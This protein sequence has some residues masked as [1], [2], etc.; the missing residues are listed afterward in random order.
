MASNTPSTDVV[1]SAFD[2]TSSADAYPYPLR[3]G[4][5]ARIALAG[6]RPSSEY[7]ESPGL[8]PPRARASSAAPVRSAFAFAFASTSSAAASA[9]AAS[10]S[11]PT[12]RRSA[13][14]ERR[15]RLS[16]GRSLARFAT[17]A[18]L[19]SSSSSSSGAHANAFGSAPPCPP[20]P[21]RRRRSA[22]A[23]SA[24]SRFASSASLSFSTSDSRTRATARRSERIRANAAIAANAAAAPR[25]A[26]DRHPSQHGTLIVGTLIVGTL[27][28][29]TRI[30]GTRIVG[31]R[32]GRKRGGVRAGGWRKRG[33]AIDHTFPTRA[34]RIVV[35]L[36]VR[37][38]AEIRVDVARVRLPR[39]VIVGEDAVAHER[40]AGHDG[41]PPGADPPGDSA[42]G[43]VARLGGADD[44][45][46]G[47]AVHGGFVT[48]E[49]AVFEQSAS[50]V[51]GDRA[52]AARSVDVG[53]IVGEDD[54][55][56]DERAV[57]EDGAAVASRRP[58][59]TPRARTT[60]TRVRS[61]RTP[62]V[63][64]REAAPASRTH[65]VGAHAPRISS[66]FST[67]GSSSPPRSSEAAR[68]MT[69]VGEEEATRAR[70]SARVDTVACGGR[71]R[72]G[73][74]RRLRE[75]APGRTGRGPLL[76]REVGDRIRG[77]R[78]RA[79]HEREDARDARRREEHRWFATRATRATTR[80]RGESHGRAGVPMARRSV[81]ETATTQ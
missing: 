56:R 61:P 13:P 42:E 46:H 71:R 10:K 31:A 41:E 73:R 49:R 65:A 44:D 50:V 29:G 75:R 33:R 17:T 39:V 28:V 22:A 20:V 43:R 11:A 2:S 72:R 78:D 8:P 32:R 48:R 70:R 4:F 67:T 38:R 69:A 24:A 45:F 6:A 35:R 60:S 23:A 53:A 57:D 3:D 62:T 64:C 47:A 1:S 68:V 40:G 30:V 74:G 36:K 19:A 76:A 59:A 63:R 51:D 16:L 79:R 81:D 7:P 21:S 9:A 15:P 54:A 77:T 80:P 5:R 55:A 58:T 66:A 25:D 27:I 14:R 26:L 52:S 18:S 37:R 34:I 12:T